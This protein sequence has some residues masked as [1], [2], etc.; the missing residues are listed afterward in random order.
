[1]EY[2]CD[3]LEKTKGAVKEF[4]KTL[5]PLPD[6]ATIVE[7]IGD[8]GAGKTTFTKILG[9]ELRIQETII[10][11][12][13]VIQKRYPIPNHPHFKTLVH[14]DAYRFENPDEAKILGIEEDIQNK[15]NLILIEW[16]S[17]I[18]NHI[19]ESIQ[20]HF[21]HKDENTRIISW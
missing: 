17:K 9:E 21:E 4:L 5:S 2:I 14:V 16:P 20:I 15:E 19:P 7:L 6:Q 11:P 18:Q 13:F 10:S 8:L 12:T 3:S 1:M